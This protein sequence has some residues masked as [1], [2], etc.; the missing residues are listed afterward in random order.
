[1]KP[2]TPAEER[3]LQDDMAMC[4]FNARIARAWAGEPEPP[5]VEEIRRRM[6]AKIAKLDAAAKRRAA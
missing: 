6:R 4:A 5:T 2:L 1:M 3:A